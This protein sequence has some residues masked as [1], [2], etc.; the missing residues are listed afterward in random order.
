MT[1]A[2]IERPPL[3]SGIVVE[4]FSHPRDLPADA[5]ALLSRAEQ[6]HIEFGSSAMDMSAYP[7][8][9]RNSQ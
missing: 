7:H 6:Q 5:V 4:R 8:S 2:A 9:E 1:S 3:L